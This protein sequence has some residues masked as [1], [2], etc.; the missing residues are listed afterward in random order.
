VT[1]SNIIVKSTAGE[2]VF[3]RIAPSFTE[4][5]T[6]N[7]AKSMTKERVNRVLR[8]KLEPLKSPWRK[9]KINALRRS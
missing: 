9:Q 2:R 4:A 5:Q 6:S 7:R 3:V 8:S 1:A